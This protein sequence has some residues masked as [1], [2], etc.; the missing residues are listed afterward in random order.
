MNPF[1]LTFS[2]IATLLWFVPLAS[3][4]AEELPGKP[5]TVGNPAEA[6]QLPSALLAA[7]AGGA[8]DITI[9]PGI[10]VLPAT[11]R[12]TIELISW[13][14]VRAQARGVTLVF[15][16]LTRRPVYLR[17]CDGVTL[18]GAVLRFARPAFT[19]G[20]IVE[21]GRDDRGDYLD[22]RIDAGYSTDLDPVKSTFD[23]ADQRTRLIMADTGDVGSGSARRSATGVF[24]CGKATGASARP[25]SGIGCS[26]A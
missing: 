21:M 11:G 5:V 8:R 6:A 22:W 23:V 10:Y 16:E 18:E 1:K 14:N 20:R 17:D 19:Q 15:E 7:Y 2:F 24:A 4:G 25:R 26:R 13:K 9:S 3:W 12:N